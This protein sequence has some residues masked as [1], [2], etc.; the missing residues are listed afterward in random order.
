METRNTRLCWSRKI[1]PCTV[2]SKTVSPA[3]KFGHFSMKRERRASRQGNFKNFDFFCRKLFWKSPNRTKLRK[4]DQH[5]WTHCS[6]SRIH[7]KT[8]RSDRYKFLRFYKEMM[9]TRWFLLGSCCPNTEWFS[10]NKKTGRDWSKM[11]ENCRKWPK[12]NLEWP[13]MTWNNL[14]LVLNWPEN[15]LFHH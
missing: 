8:F 4:S 6:L 15:D 13:K 14:K 10:N 1:C 3:A 7:R 12:I 5:F 2:R 11:A 9:C